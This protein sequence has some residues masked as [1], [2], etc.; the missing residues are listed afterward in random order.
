[1]RSQGSEPLVQAHG[2]SASCRAVSGRVLGP[3]PLCQMALRKS[4]V[5]EE[6]PQVGDDGWAG[7]SALPGQ[8]RAAPCREG[9]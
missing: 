7:G 6:D 5:G 8:H 9:Q 1:M 2:V 3:K 4:L